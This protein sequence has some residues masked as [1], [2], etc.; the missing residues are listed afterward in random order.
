MQ[1][2]YSTSEITS[3][4]NKVDPSS[5]RKK[6]FLFVG[7]LFLLK[8]FLAFWLELGNDEAYYWLYSQYLQWN[9]FDH[10]LM[11]AIWIRLFTAN[12]SLDHLEGFVRLGS[13]TGSVLASWFLFKTVALLHSERAGWYATVLYNISFYSAI[14]A[15]LY[16]LPD[17]PQM[18]FWTLGLLL[19]AKIIKQEDSWINWLLFGF[20]AG[21]CIMSKVH[22]AF[23]W[24]GMGG[25]ILFRRNSWFKKPQLYMA[26]L[27]TVIIIS[28]ILFWNVQY[29]F[30]TFRFHSNRVDIDELVFKLN[31]FLKEAG[32]QIG[33]NNPVVFFLAVSALGAFYRG[34]ISYQPALVIYSMIGVPLAFL[35]LFVSIF[36]NVTLPHWS[37]PAYVSFMPLAAIWLAEHSQN[38]F[39]KILRWGLGTFL[40][41]Y[42]GYSLVVKFYPGT[43]GSHKE[44]N[45]GNGDIS[46][47]MYGWKKA[48]V[49]FD[50]L[51]K[52]DVNKRNMSANAAMV[53]TNWWGA[54]VEYYFARPLGL[55]M[56]GL[57]N[58]HHL[59]EYLWTNKWRRNE[60]DLNNAYCII[61]ADDKYLVPADFYETKELALII[62]VN[63][64][65]KPAHKFL[66]YRLKGLKKDMPVVS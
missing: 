35:L 54:H 36:R 6:F 34:K 48:A 31:Y 32:S 9:Y 42:L 60:V 37:G 7:I 11:V 13:V 58:P 28:P 56:I 61:P 59:N 26:F 24:I 19:I 15:G 20:V 55:K 12:L 44:E 5:Y 10:P 62:I 50:S 3:Q 66:M 2:F 16:I 53:T 23:L 8:L 43:Y 46:L 39:P 63:R 57:G 22:G 25:Y 52:A 41:V 45:F 18:V 1:L 33:F 29:D 38:S 4:Q 64:N 65:G 14:T 30:A 47:D 49:Q 27:I 21:L 40:V 51:Y 17:S